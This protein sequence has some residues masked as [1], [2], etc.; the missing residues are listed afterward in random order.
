MT[1]A[2]KARSS[3]EGYDTEFGARPLRRAIQRLLENPLSSELLRGTVQAG[4]TIRVDAGE[5][6]RSGSPRDR[7][8]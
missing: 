7:R 4:D 3:D 8:A 1:E 5:T 2:A 6:V